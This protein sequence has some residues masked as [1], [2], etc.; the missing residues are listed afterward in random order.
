M[1]KQR[2]VPT[3]FGRVGRRKKAGRVVRRVREGFTAADIL[4][5]AREHCP[6]IIIQSTVEKVDPKDLPVTC[7]M[8]YDETIPEEDKVYFDPPKAKGTDNAD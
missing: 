8:V 6:S 7:I 3:L 2:Y 1:Q 4:A 5:Y